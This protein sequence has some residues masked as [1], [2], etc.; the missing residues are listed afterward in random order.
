MPAMTRHVFLTTLGLIDL[1]GPS[2]NFFA[3]SIDWKDS[4]VDLKQC[5]NEMNC[6]KG[7]S[8]RCLDNVFF[9][10]KI[11]IVKF[12]SARDFLPRAKIL[13]CSWEKGRGN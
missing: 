2:A 5:W 11:K 9:A 3:Y 8:V 12:L 10:L 7:P 1:R 6:N 4:G 13:K